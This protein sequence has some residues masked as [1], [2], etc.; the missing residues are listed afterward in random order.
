MV[1]FRARTASRAGPGSVTGTAPRASTGSG[2]SWGKSLP[3]RSGESPEGM[4]RAPLPPGSCGSRSGAAPSTALLHPL[5][6]AFQSCSG[7]FLSRWRAIAASCRGS[8]RWDAGAVVRVGLLGRLG[9]GVCPNL[10]QRP[11]SRR[12]AG[13]ESLIFRASSRG[14]SRPGA[15]LQQIRTHPRPEPPQEPHPHHPAP[16]RATT[17]IPAGPGNFLVRRAHCAVSG[18]EECGTRGEKHALA[19]FL[20][21]RTARPPVRPRPLRHF[22]SATP[23]H[24]PLHE[25]KK[26]SGG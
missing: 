20:N 17:T 12:G 1:S 19:A 11:R 22:P 25:K 2:R 21:R 5:L 23:F 3:L 10:L 15:P 16:A 6:R 9:A 14:R 4:G 13:G 24:P 8:P 26:R 18:R 7:P